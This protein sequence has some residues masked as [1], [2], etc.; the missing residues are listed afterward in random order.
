MIIPYRPDINLTRWPVFTVTIMVLCFAVF[1]AQRSSEKSI[2]RHASEYCTGEVAQDIEYPWE[3]YFNH[4]TPC[5]YVLLSLYGASDP[6]K[7]LKQYQELILGR[8]D[9]YHAERLASHYR[10]FAASAPRDL[11]L[12]LAYHSSSWNPL[13][14]LTSSFSHGSWEHLLGNLFFFF[15][16]AMVVE[17]IVGPVLFLLVFVSM[18][19]GIGVIDSLANIGQTD[20]PTLGISGEVFGMLTLALFFVPRVKI[21]FFYWFLVLFGSFSVPLWMVAGWYI[22][23]NIYDYATMADSDINYIAHLGGAAVGLTMGLTVF[24]EKRH[25][26]NGLLPGVSHELESPSIL[27]Q[28]RNITAIPVILIAAYLLLLLVFMLILYFVHSFSLQLILSSPVI[29]MGYFLYRMR[30][31]NRPDWQQYQKAMKYVHEQNYLQALKVLAP[32]A[33]AGYPRAQYQLGRLY[34]GGKGVIKDVMQAGYWYELAAHRGH[35]QAQDELASLYIDG[36]GVNR[37]MQA[38]LH[39]LDKA[40]RTLPHSAMRL[41]YYFEHHPES[42]KRDLAAAVNAYGQAGDLFLKGKALADAESVLVTLT[43]LAPG[44][45]VTENLQIR[46]NEFKELP[47]SRR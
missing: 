25:W 43:N 1:L 37:D 26:A 6:A 35:A 12:A 3:R 40:A 9:A 11:T 28:A 39:W 16:F 29:V 32:L 18:S 15:A 46:I 38:A 17:M 8:H 30:I 10:A 23:W 14:M 31:A 20:I 44:H 19:L 13:R 5:R 45:Q 42:S 21:K 2:E 41:G 24:R 22:G 27:T 4:P 7:K 33:K 47:M 34:L 36:N